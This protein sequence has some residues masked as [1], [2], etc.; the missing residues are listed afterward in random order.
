[1]SSAAAEDPGNLAVD[2][3]SSY[4]V[5]VPRNFERAIGGAGSPSA[6][7]TSARRYSS[8]RTYSTVYSQEIEC[9][10]V[11][12]AAGQHVGWGEAQA[13]VAPEI[14][15]AIVE[16]L[17]GPLVVGR[18]AASPASTYTYLYD[19]MRVRGHS[20]GFYLDALA[21]IDMA[22]WDLLGKVTGTPVCDLL[23]GRVRDTIPAYVS[24][25]PGNTSDEC[26][27][28]AMDRAKLGATAFKVFW[29][30]DFDRELRLLQKLRAELPPTTELY[31]D[32]LWRMNTQQAAYYSRALAELR[33]GWLEAPLIPEDIRGHSWLCGVAGTPIAVGE[34]YR[35]SFDFVRLVEESAAHILQPDLGRCG[36]TT[37]RFV[38]QLC[39]T[40][41]L[42]FAPHVS[43]GLGPQLAAA[44][45]VSAAAPTLIR[46]ES[47]PDVLEVARKFSDITAVRELA[48]FRVPSGPGLGIAMSE[49]RLHPFVTAHATLT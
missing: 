38:T 12:I 9:L 18:S 33:I 3:V 19:A 30:N 35:S 16:H 2:S 23:G 49:E 43:I 6:L 1:M 15:H 39:A 11:K 22:L 10:L 4:V 25:I 40:R 36:I 20:G 13:P 24:G 27:H 14:C 32:S 26:L 8:A 34:S 47:N 45:H 44:L 5:R 29:T 7:E 42:G 37:T 48:E 21:A 17:V 31:V 46:A 28:Y 41:N